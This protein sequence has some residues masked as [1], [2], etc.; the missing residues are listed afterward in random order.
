MLKGVYLLFIYKI[1]KNKYMC[2]CSSSIVYITFT[3]F[4]LKKDLLLRNLWMISCYIFRSD[5]AALHMFCYKYTHVFFIKRFITSCFLYFYYSIT[6]IINFIVLFSLIFL[7]KIL[8]YWFSFLKCLG[9]VLLRTYFFYISQNS[10]CTGMLT[11]LFL[12]YSFTN[13]FWQNFW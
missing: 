1:F 10:W 9:S 6:F 3:S 7:K 13:R 4:S 11:K 8:V 5:D 2:I 12:T